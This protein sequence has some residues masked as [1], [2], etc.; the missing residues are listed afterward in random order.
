MPILVSENRTKEIWFTSF[1]GNSLD[2]FTCK[3]E[4][5]NSTF[6][7][8]CTP[9]IKLFGLLF[10]DVI[11]CLKSKQ[12]CSDFRHSKSQVVMAFFQ[13]F[14]CRSLCVVF[15]V[16]LTYPR[17]KKTN[18]PWFPFLFFAGIVSVQSRKGLKQSGTRD[19]EKGTV[20]ELNLLELTQ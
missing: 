18:P 5:Q 15:V 3:V 13:D 20:V 1:F 8:Q 4:R 10:S 7:F 14:P 12:F 17:Y 16:L 11:F 19:N 6:G 9:K 2:H